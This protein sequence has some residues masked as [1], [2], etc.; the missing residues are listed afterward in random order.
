[1]PVQVPVPMP[2]Q[3][4]CNPCGFQMPMSNPCMNPC[5]NL[6]LPLPMKCQ[7]QVS[8]VQVP[9]YMGFRMPY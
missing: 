4:S 3:R 6:S 1:M 8:Q 5:Q 2:C 9:G 7:I